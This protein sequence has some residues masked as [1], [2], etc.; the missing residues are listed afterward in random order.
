[1]LQRELP[2]VRESFDIVCIVSSPDV[3]AMRF[4]ELEKCVKEMLVSANLYKADT[5]DAI[6][7]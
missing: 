4:D 7:G 3:H 1:M 2:H 6:I 5:K